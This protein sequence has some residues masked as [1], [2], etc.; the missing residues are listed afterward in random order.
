MFKY[1]IKYPK[2]HINND[3]LIRDGKER[4]VSDFIA[5]MTDRYAINLHKLIKWTYF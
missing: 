3:L 5:G 2:K 4:A 1:L